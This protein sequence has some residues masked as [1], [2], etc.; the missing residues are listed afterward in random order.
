MSITTQPKEEF[1]TFKAT[2]EVLM[3]CHNCMDNV[4][5]A[6]Q[7]DAQSTAVCCGAIK[8]FIGWPFALL[9]DIFSCPVR[10]CIHYK[11]QS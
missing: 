5:S 10:K 6:N 4:P 7:T 3:G 1:I 2:T 9:F 8:C 11:N